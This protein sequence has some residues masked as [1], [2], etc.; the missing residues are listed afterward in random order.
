MHERFLKKTTEVASQ[1]ELRPTR[2]SSKRL[3]FV[4]RLCLAEAPVERLEE[5]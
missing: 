1:E 3:R 2:T 4:F 5:R